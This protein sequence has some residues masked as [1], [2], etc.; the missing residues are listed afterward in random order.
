MKTTGAII[1]EL[2]EAYGMS[3]QRL[4]ELVG[5]KSYTTIT[6]WENDENHPR[7]KEIKILCNLFNVSADYLLGLKEE[8]VIPLHPYKY[9][10]VPISAGLP[11]TVDAMDEF[12][13][14]LISLP[15]EVMGRWARKS[16]IFFV[17][18]N[19]ES[20]NKIFPHNA[21]L[22]VKMVSLH[23][24]NDNDIVIFSYDN[25]YSV[26]RFKQDSKSNKIIFRPE[27]L[28]ETF[29]DIVIE[30]EQKEFLQIV[31]KVVTYVVTT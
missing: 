3:K 21:L 18:A 1:K 10:P 7:G 8:R 26:K 9:I 14:S 12:E 2:R 5:A 22:G 16:D 6:K 23:E 4:A 30:E 29:T 11:M 17:K 15:D 25:E 20:M 13:C 19:G 27:S 24:L 28:D 31:G